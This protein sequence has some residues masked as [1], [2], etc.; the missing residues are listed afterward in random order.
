MLQTAFGA[1]CMNRASVFEWPYEK[2]S[3]NLSNETC[4]SWNLDKQ[5]P[6]YTKNS[7]YEKG[8]EEISVSFNKN[9]F[10]FRKRKSK[11]P[12]SKGKASLFV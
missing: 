4:I 3:G 6:H 10:K 2:K 1:S 12:D 5:K 7:E 9:I 11:V 8:F